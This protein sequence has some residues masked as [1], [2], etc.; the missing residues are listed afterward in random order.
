[1]CEMALC[2]LEGGA[3]VA[4]RD[5]HEFHLSQYL[6]EGGDEWGVLGDLLL[7][8]L[9]ASK[10]LAK[11]DLDDNEGA[12]LLVVGGRVRGGGVRY[13]ARVDEVRCCSVAGKVEFL[14]L[15]VREYPFRDTVRCRRAFRVVSCGGEEAP[16]VTKFL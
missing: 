12:E 6:F 5:C 11:S 8:P 13:A 10:V 14:Y 7:E 3:G 2:F 1:M 4:D 9:V 16:C 15:S